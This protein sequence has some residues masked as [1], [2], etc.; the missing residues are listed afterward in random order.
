ML[1]ENAR[2]NTERLE[3]LVTDLIDVARLQNL[4]LK[5]SLD[6]RDLRQLVKLAGES[7]TP[8]MAEK[9][10]TLEFFLPERPIIVRCDHQRLEQVLNNLLMNAHQHTPEHDPD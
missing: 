8:L 10:Q 1:L 2:R 9:A 7:F 4:Q 6:A 5:L 3:R